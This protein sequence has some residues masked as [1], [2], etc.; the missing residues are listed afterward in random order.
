MLSDYSFDDQHGM[1]EEVRDD[2]VGCGRLTIVVPLVRRSERRKKTRRW[3]IAANQG[4]MKK[5]RT[6]LPQD[7]R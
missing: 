6:H 2:V 4:F 3:R 7:R 5:S 1:D